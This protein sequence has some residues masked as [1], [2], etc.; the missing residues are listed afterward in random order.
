MHVIIVNGKRGH[1][2]ERGQDMYLVGLGIWK[3]KGKI[4]NKNSGS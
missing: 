2:F 3:G 1:E 4:C